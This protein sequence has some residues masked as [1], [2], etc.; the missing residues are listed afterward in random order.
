MDIQILKGLRA[1]KMLL[2]SVTGKAKVYI[3]ISR[4]NNIIIDENTMELVA[5]VQGI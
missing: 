4:S 2:N 3:I 5:R 1:T